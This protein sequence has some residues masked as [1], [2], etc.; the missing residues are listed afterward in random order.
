MPFASEAAIPEV[1]CK[2]VQRKIDFDEFRAIAHR[3]ES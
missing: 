3:L 1:D 2:I